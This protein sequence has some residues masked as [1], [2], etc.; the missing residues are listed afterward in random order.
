[1]KSFLFFFS[2]HFIDKEE[3]EFSGDCPSDKDVIADEGKTDKLV[4][5][6][7]ITATDNDGQIPDMQVTPN[8]ISPRD[9]SHTFSEGTHRVTFTARDRAGNIKTCSF[10]V[11]VKGISCLL[12]PSDETFEVINGKLM[13]RL[14]L[15]TL[16]KFSCEI[17]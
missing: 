6:G 8:G 13:F 4:G 3:P 12:K 17:H 9:T 16:Q 10:N 5:W 1:M 14:R 2:I 7:P 15:G 11:E